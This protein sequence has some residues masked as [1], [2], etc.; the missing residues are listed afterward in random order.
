VTQGPVDLSIIIV[1][2]NAC[3]DVVRCLDSLHRAPAGT[4]H[5]VVIVDNASTDGTVETI[6]AR[7]PDVRIVEIGDN[8]G[9][10]A[11]NNVGIRSSRGEL[12]LILNGD[13]VIPPG[14]IDRLAAELERHSDVAAIGPRIVDP[15]GRPELSFGRMVGP[16]AEFSQRRLVHGNNRRDPGASARVEQMTR[17]QQDVDWISGACMLLRRRDAEAAGLFDERYFLYFEDVDFCAAIRRLE[18]RVLFFPAV[19]IAHARGRSAASQP[20]AVN[21]AYRRSQLAFYQKHHPLWVP[22][23]RLYLRFRGEGAMLS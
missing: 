13:T 8:I 2:H 5:E 7:W 4:P 14:A 15:E 6:G 17:V 21:H 1:T 11:A 16:L 23:L 3:A 12:I 10:G 19:E 18:R 20:D 22:V 9:F